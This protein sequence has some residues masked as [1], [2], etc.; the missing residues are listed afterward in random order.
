[1]ANP[2][3]IVAG[4]TAAAEFLATLL[5]DDGASR[6]AALPEQVDAYSNLDFHRSPW[7]GIARFARYEPE[8]LLP[9]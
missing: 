7:A 9:M 8:P 6:I 3:R 1:M 4:N 5:G 2:Q